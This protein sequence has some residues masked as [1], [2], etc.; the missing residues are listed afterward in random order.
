MGSVT[1]QGPNGPRLKK[2]RV[3]KNGVE[4]VDESSDDTNSSDEDQRGRKKPVA[5]PHVVTM[6]EIRIESKKYRP[7]MN[8]FE[9]IDQERK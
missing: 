6:E 2:N 9:A 7:P 1:D 8:M 5:R 3:L 4:V